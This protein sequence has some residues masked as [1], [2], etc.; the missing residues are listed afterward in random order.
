MEKEANTREMKSDLLK[1]DLLEEVKNLDKK[2]ASFINEMSSVLFQTSL[3]YLL[4]FPYYPIMEKSHY[5]TGEE[6]FD[7]DS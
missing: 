4:H 1:E 2:Y 5:N 6:V 3:G 7:S